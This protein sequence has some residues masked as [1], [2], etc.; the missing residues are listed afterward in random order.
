MWRIR[1]QPL[2]ELLQS[3]LHA[4]QSYCRPKSKSL[5][6]AH[7]ETSPIHHQSLSGHCLWPAFSKIHLSFN[8]KKLKCFFILFCFSGPF[9]PKL[10]PSGN[11]LFE[12]QRGSQCIWFRAWSGA[13][14]RCGECRASQEGRKGAGGVGQVP[15]MMLGGVGEGSGCRAWLRGRV[16]MRWV[17]GASGRARDGHNQT[18]PTAAPPNSSQSKPGPAGS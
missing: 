13:W 15:S 6:A 4:L 16:R 5:P 14:P 8:F 12:H 11:V 17:P 7:L 9:P 3:S 18:P 2:P 1:R 10:P